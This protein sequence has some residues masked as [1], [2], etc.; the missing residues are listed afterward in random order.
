MQVYQSLASYQKG[1]KT[2]ATIGTFDGVHLGHK[3]ILQRLK[4]LS[5]EI[6]GESVLISFHPHPRLVLAPEKKDLQLLQTVGEKIESLTA[7]GIDKLLLI[8][9][10]KD[11][12]NITATDFVEEVLI[13]TVDVSRLVIGYDHHFGKNRS[14]NIHE[15]R[16]LAPVYGFEVEEIPAEA[17]DNASI[18]STK[19]RHAILSGEIQTANTF[20]GY[21]FRFSGTVIHGEKQGR[22]LGYPTANL[23]LTDPFKIIPAN[24]IYCVRVILGE[25]SYGGMMSIGYKPTMGEFKR[26]I[27][28]NIFNFDQ[29]I[30][31]E[32][33]TI[34]LLAYIRP[35][36]KFDSLPAL[37]EAIDGDKVFCMNYFSANL[38]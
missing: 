14:G 20:L 17:I 33:L 31:G 7:F 24:G 12:S 25:Q 22:Q 18:S 16:A 10:T 8:P 38:S 36:K 35:E 9:F 19:I 32:I 6:R 1:K 27:E 4:D 29:E 11:F 37:I 5:Q 26:G 15:L 34:E 23:E 28:V 3:K 13:N 21:P 2:V 30:Y